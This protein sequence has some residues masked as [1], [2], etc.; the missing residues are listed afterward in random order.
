MR[1][2]KEE[3]EFDQM[4]KEEIEAGNPFSEY[5][6]YRSYLSS[7]PRKKKIDTSSIPKQEPLIT[8]QAPVTYSG[9]I[10]S[11]DDNITFIE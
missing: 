11:S 6:S 4:M 5:S 10:I 3:R 1:K 2:T 9:K 8:G 7:K